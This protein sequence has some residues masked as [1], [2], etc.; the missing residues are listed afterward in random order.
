MN[1]RSYST[2]LAGAVTATN[3]AFGAA[4]SPI[5]QADGNQS[6]MTPEPGS[7]ALVG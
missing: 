4:S 6:F 1:D 3:L 5:F 2:T 7:L